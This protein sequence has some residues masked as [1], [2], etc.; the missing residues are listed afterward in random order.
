MGLQF[1][2]LHY[3]PTTWLSRVDLFLL[4]LRPFLHPA[5]RSGSR[6]HRPDARARAGGRRND[7]Q[8]P[9]LILA[10]QSPNVLAPRLQRIGLVLLGADVLAPWLPPVIRR[11]GGFVIVIVIVA[12]DGVST[13]AAAALILLRAGF[14]W[15]FSTSTG[16][17]GGDKGGEG[18]AAEVLLGRRWVDHFVSEPHRASDRG[19]GYGEGEG[20][21]AGADGMRGTVQEKGPHDRK[22]NA[23]WAV[24]L[25]KL[26]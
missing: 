9:P 15:V 8:F 10:V 20:G 19:S 14:F 24:V 17:G 1:I 6:S 7:I 13:G 12:G 21:E 22:A 23:G 18:F 25:A 11:G 5:I 26:K 4:R 2:R 16:A 3:K